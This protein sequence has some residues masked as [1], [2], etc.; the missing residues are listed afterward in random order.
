M[1]V[2]T[3]LSLIFRVQL[4]T[5]AVLVLE[6]RMAKGYLLLNAYIQKDACAKNMKFTPSV[7]ITIL[8]TS[9][10]PFC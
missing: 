7:Q 10:S 2:K 6:E 4:V 5:E 3:K 8:H 9:S 1:E